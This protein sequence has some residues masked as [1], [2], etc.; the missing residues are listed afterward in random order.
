M[1]NDTKQNSKIINAVKDKISSFIEDNYVLLEG[2]FV[3]TATVFDHFRQAEGLDIARDKNETFSSA[4]R[5]FCKLLN[6]AKFITIKR[7]VGMVLVDY[8]IKDDIKDD[9][10][11]LSAEKIELV[12]SK[13]YSLW[14]ENTPKS[15]QIDIVKDVEHQLKKNDLVVDKR[16]EA[17]PERANLSQQ[18]PRVH[19]RESVLKR[20]KELDKF[21]NENNSIQ[22]FIESEDFIQLKQ[23]NQF[24]VE[25][26]DVLKQQVQQLT[27]ILLDKFAEQNNINS[28]I[29]SKYNKL[30]QQVKTLNF[31]FDLLTDKFENQ[32]NIIAD[33][34]LTKSKLEQQVQ[35]LAD[36][37]SELLEKY[38]I[39]ASF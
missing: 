6:D 28:S 17:E 9:I 21:N 31:I 37:T 10:K 16:V 14:K 34:E 15:E 20:R 29:E 11:M 36:S 35:Y 7:D 26:N 13:K 38:Y 33:L 24:L 5:T 1:N 19:A 25:S 3:K 8:H 4:N 39:S 23:E 22:T 32:N 27:N 12:N 18:V 2:S 30:E